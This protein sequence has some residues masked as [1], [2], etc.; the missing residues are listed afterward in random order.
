MSNKKSGFD[1]IAYNKQYK[2]DNY[3]RAVTYYK[4]EDYN[5]IAMYCKDFNLSFG[6]YVKMCV[7]YCVENV[8]I[9]ELKHYKK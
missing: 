8:H 2:K 6:E 9:D 4:I 7:N 1:V 5:N 3:K